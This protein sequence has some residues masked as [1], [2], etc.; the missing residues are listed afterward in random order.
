MYKNN[1]KTMQ[2]IEFSLVIIKRFNG[3]D[4]REQGCW[5]VGVL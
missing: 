1:V 3:K 2:S 4:V 5:T